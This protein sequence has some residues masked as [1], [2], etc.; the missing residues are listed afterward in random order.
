M[1]RSTSSSSRRSAR[2][3]FT[4][5]QAPYPQAPLAWDRHRLAC[6]LAAP[7]AEIPPPVRA[8]LAAWRRRPTRAALAALLLA[9]RDSA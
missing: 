6:A 7:E 2:S 5:D 4:T 9:A 3:A 1:R 8:A